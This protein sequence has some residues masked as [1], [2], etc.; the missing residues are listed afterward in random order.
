MLSRIFYNAYANKNHN[1][2]Y[3]QFRK[4]NQ[5]GQMITYLILII[6]SVLVGLTAV[7]LYGRKDHL[8]PKVFLTGALIN[9]G[10]LLGVMLFQKRR[11]S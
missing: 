4:T 3:T 2:N 5:G 10:A 7:L 9:A 11:K 8:D 6:T 1:R